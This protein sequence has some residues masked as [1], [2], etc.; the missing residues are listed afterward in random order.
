M[1]NFSLRFYSIIELTLKCLWFAYSVAVVAAAAVFHEDE[2]NVL[3]NYW[4][5]ELTCKLNQKTYKLKGN[6][7]Q[8]KSK[9]Y[10]MKKGEARSSMIIKLIG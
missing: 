1:K 3:E 7:A 2:E 4:K 6:A 10:G 9:K 5:Y 8:T